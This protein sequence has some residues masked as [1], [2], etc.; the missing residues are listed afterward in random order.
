[1]SRVKLLV[2]FIVIVSIG[3]VLFRLFLFPGENEA[4]PAL[5]VVVEETATGLGIVYLPVTHGLS[6]YYGLGI[7]YGA[8]VTE[9]VPGS[10]ADQSGI[11]EGD[12]ITT[13]DDAIIEPETQLLGMM[14]ACP[15]GHVITLELRRG[16]ETKLIKIAHMTVPE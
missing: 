16:A 6:Q 14:I 7:D 12:I 4:P 15:S 1:M 11:K 5:P 10:P 9:V 13:F 8:L 2:F 3:V